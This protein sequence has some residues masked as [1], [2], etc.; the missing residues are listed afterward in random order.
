MNFIRRNLLNIEVLIG[1]VGLSLNKSLYKKLLVVQEAYRQQIEMYKTRTRRISGRIVNINQPHIRPIV[2]G[3][4][5]VPVEFGLK[6]SMSVVNGYSFIDRT[7]WDAYN[8]SQDL[9]NQVEAYKRR[10]GFYP[11]SVHADGIYRTR[12]NISY[13][14]KKGI[15]LSGPKLGRPKQE[16]DKAEKKQ[17]HQDAVDR[18]AIEGKFGQAKRRFGLNRIFTKL[19][20]TSLNSVFMIVL[21]MN[22]EK[23]MDSLFV[24]LLFW[25]KK[26]K[27]L[28][29][30][31]VNSI[32]FKTKKSLS[33]QY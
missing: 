12:A 20:K 31:A 23:R 9:Q 27:K 29:N 4:S 7:S 8:E 13:C 21:V 16:I 25:L 6:F 33:S 15:R 22:L 30:I 26:V 1:K 11:V 10:Y 14:K 24:F 28:E 32:F 3:K 5:G 18:I 17:R 19:P 2:R